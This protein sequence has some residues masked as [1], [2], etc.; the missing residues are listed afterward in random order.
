MDFQLG[1]KVSVRGDGGTLRFIGRTQFAPGTWYGVELDT[2][3]GKND[4]SV[5][6]VKYFDCDKKDGLYGV[7]VRILLIDTGSTEVAGG[8][9]DLSGTVKQLQTKLRV[10]SQEVEKYKALIEKYVSL[11][12][13][14]L[15]RSSNLE[16]SLESAVVDKEYLEDSNSQMT[17]QLRELQLK[18]EELETDYQ[19]LKEEAEI[20][21]QIEAEIK[22]ELENSDKSEEVKL[23]VSR[24]KQLELTLVNLQ[25]LSKDSQSAL[26]DEIQRLNT[27]IAE[28]EKQ[29]GL[30]KNAE[31]RLAEAESNIELLRKQLDST[32]ELEKIIENLNS[33]NEELQ[34]ELERLSRDVIELTEL[35]DLDRALEENQKL[36]EN[37]LRSTITNLKEQI[38][39]DKQ[40]LFNVLKQNKYLES[41]I[42]GIS[43]AVESPKTTYSNDKT[44]L[45]TS[46]EKLKV[47][48]KSQQRISFQNSLERE[49]AV[50]ML[51]YH[52]WKAPIS[53]NS[54]ISTKI[55]YLKSIVVPL[56]NHVY[57]VPSG[58]LLYEKSTP[59][60]SHT[61]L[62]IVYALLVFVEEFWE[63]NFSS[64]KAEELLLLLDNIEVS[65]NQIKAKFLEANVEGL[66]FTF[67]EEF[68]ESTN[69][70]FALETHDSSLKRLGRALYELAIK[71]I[72]GCIKDFI[73]LTG[74][75]NQLVQ[76]Y[77]E[78]GSRGDI[79]LA[80]KQDVDF[81]LLKCQKVDA[82]VKK[83]VQFLKEC[84]AKIDIDLQLN[85]YSFIDIL[86]LVLNPTKVLLRIAKQ[87]EIEK[88]SISNMAKIEYGTME[89]IF[90]MK[91]GLLKLLKNHFET[92][93]SFLEIE[94]VIEQSN[95]ISW[96]KMESE[97]PS[98]LSTDSPADS[99]NLDTIRMLNEKAM[100][101][102]NK[103]ND[104]QVNI[105]LLESTL[106][107]SN[108]KNA[109]IILL[110]ERELKSL[111]RDHE[112]LTKKY[113]EVQ[114]E[115]VYLTEK[116]KDVTELN[117]TLSKDNII[118]PNFEKLEPEEQYNKVMSLAHENL[119]L[120]KL[121]LQ[122]STV[123]SIDDCQLQ[124]LEVTHKHSKE[125]NLQLSQA[126]EFYVNAKR[127]R[128]IIPRV[129]PIKVNY[130][131][132][133]INLHKYIVAT[134]ND[135]VQRFNPSKSIIRHQ[136]QSA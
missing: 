102:E 29:L 26:R 37:E 122:R 34:G 83:R 43:S 114:T 53:E 30:S 81:I 27:R 110:L 130:Q 22:N 79:D 21:K 136:K 111:K 46:Y 73:L 8:N 7:F 85:S 74:D 16:S 118:I 95:A 6:G 76:S 70:L 124:P 40:K 44:E 33:K 50:K 10:T 17:T 57:D 82:L 3:H 103:I 13:Q 112:G 113:A 59:S 9:S 123:K 68:I 19:I 69:K 97:A 65:I 14:A 25:K 87:I 38:Q 61:N 4:G 45:E 84:E 11:H 99:E 66:N 52:S 80:L 120:K 35:H 12:K 62:E 116:V 101:R 24:N 129:T 117:L 67:I 56:K 77:F 106:T 109:E 55:M 90:E 32:L 2:K 5:N 127:F 39:V 78:T 100:E 119:I 36:V 63:Y 51:E 108:N 64:S 115:L 41:K 93:Q 18:F 135:D 47:D 94:P 42:S 88:N 58:E 128:D 107:S 49:L 121:L 28:S 131:M 126:K 23:L 86:V 75:M 133:V 71:I 91:E 105:S 72:E 60:T 104:L 20:N 132:R 54:K 89:F 31:L 48:F 1:Q 15:E 92:L 134:M 125:S 96:R 98:S